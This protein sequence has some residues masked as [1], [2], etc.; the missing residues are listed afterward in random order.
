V[1]L[2]DNFISHGLFLT[3]GKKK[4]R[5]REHD[6]ASWI[7]CV[8]VDGTYHSDFQIIQISM[9]HEIIE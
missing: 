9:Y 5:E 1:K 3:A 2:K 4:S 6:H 7:H 8:V